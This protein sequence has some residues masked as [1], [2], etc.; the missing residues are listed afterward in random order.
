MTHAIGVVNGLEENGNEVEI[1]AEEGVLNFTG[2]INTS[3]KIRTLKALSKLDHFYFLT[4]RSYIHS[5][6]VFLYRKTIFSF[7][8]IIWFRLL[9]FNRKFKIVSEVNGFVFDYNQKFKNKKRLIAFTELLHKLLLRYDDLVYVVNEDLKNKLITGVCALP[10]E[11]VIVVH[12]GGPQPAI[13]SSNTMKSSPINLVFFGILADYN[14]LDLCIDAIHNH[15]NVNLHIIGFGP[16]LEYLK[17][18]AGN[19]SNVLF[20]GA[21]TFEEFGNIIRDMQG[22]RIGLIP[23]NLGNEKSSLSPIKAFDYMSFGLP[24]IYSNICLTDIVKSGTEG[25]SYIAGD[26]QSLKRTIQEI[27]DPETYLHLKKCVISNYRHHTWG[28]RMK[29]LNEALKK[30]VE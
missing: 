15:D 23:M 14:E 18:K 26:I 22:L 12:N 7:V 8:W 20:Y 11:K 21:K 1:L 16:Q 2:R 17:T 13:E 3:V 25:L 29:Y 28:A 5:F 9:F 19:H 30:C 10:S 24:L 4:K 27:S 6:D